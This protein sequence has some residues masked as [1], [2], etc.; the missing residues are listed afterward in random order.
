MLIDFGTWSGSL[1]IVLFT[2]AV[3]AIFGSVLAGLLIKIFDDD[4]LAEDSRAW[5]KGHDLSMRKAA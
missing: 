1:M 2:I 5:R 3:I 4:F